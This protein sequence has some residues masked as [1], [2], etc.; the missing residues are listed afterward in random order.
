MQGSCFG[1]CSSDSSLRSFGLFK[2]MV[3]CKSDIS[4]TVHCLRI[5][6][7]FRGELWF[8]LTHLL[9]LV[10]HLC[11][12]WLE[13]SAQQATQLHDD[14]PG[15]Y[16]KAFALQTT[17]C[18]YRPRCFQT[19]SSA[20][21]E[22]V[23]FQEQQDLLPAECDPFCTQTPHSRLFDTVL[24]LDEQAKTHCV[25]YPILFWICHFIWM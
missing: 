9:V 14:K 3:L 15:R 25:C 22:E 24:Y 11:S 10:I 5:H 18:V 12:D 13:L 16:L 2:V 6:F 1:K 19:H 8:L 23:C 20:K 7:L 17:P 21:G 4:L